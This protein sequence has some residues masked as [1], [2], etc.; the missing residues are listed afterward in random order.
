[1]AYLPL[2]HVLELMCESFYLTSGIPIGYSSALTMTDTS[3]KIKKGAKGDASILQPTCLTVVPLILD[4]V[5]K[6][7]QE[8]IAAGSP[9]S[10]AAFKYFYN[11]KLKWYYRGF[12][13]PLVNKLIFQPIRQILGG[14]VRFFASGGESTIRYVDDY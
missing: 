1:M 5:Y 4:R 8:K 2:A 7:I 6:G 11:Y 14:R 13:T 3:G 10:Q 9:L 12:D